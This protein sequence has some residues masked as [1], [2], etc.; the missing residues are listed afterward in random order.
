LRGLPH[1]A[2][3]LPS[4]PGSYGRPPG[5]NTRVRYQFPGPFRVPGVS[6]EWCP[7]PAV[8]I[9]LLLPPRAAQVPAGNNLRVFIV[10]RTAAVFRIWTRLSTGLFTAYPQ[11]FEGAPLKRNKTRP[12][13]YMVWR[14]PVTACRTK[15][16]SCPAH[17]A[18][19]ADHQG[20]TPASGTSFPAPSASP[21][22]PPSGARF[23]R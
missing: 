17:P 6:P 16:A 19:M 8:E 5:P 12:P 4:S 20:Q 10:H 13:P 7:F 3:Q 11:A 1:Q 15:L 21:E 23:R 14:G 18:P 9:F 2:R 22:F